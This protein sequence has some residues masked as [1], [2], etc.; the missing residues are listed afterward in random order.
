ML[1]ALEDADW[2]PMIVSLM[3]DVISA[4]EF[5]VASLMFTFETVGIGNPI[6]MLKVHEPLPSVGV[7]CCTVA[8]PH[9]SR[10]NTVAAGVCHVLG[11]S[12]FGSGG[13]QLFGINLW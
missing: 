3:C 8:H 7:G 2:I 6:S 13:T 1:F 11:H 4:T 9:S 10:D 5:T 12:V